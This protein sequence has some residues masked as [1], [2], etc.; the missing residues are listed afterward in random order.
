MAGKQK[1]VRVVRVLAL[2]FIM[3]AVLPIGIVR[4]CAD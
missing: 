4:E 1:K 2:L 3:L